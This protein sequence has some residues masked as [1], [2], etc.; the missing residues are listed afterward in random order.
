M[1]RDGLYA[2]GARMHRNGDAH[3]WPYAVGARMHWSGATQKNWR[4]ML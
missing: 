4:L 2:V 1:P 3:G